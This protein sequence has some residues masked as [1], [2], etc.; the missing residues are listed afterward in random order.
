VKSVIPAELE[1]PLAVLLLCSEVDAEI[2]SLRAVLAS[3]EP[4]R[5]SPFPGVDGHQ[6]GSLRMIF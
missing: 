3:G 4:A 5:L 1:W 2:L 6:A